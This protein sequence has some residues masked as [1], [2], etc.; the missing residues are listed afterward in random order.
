MNSR[1][2]RCKFCSAVLPPDRHGYAKYCDA[3]RSETG[4]LTK[5]FFSVS[6]TAEVLSIKE[7][8]AMK[9]IKQGQL[10]VRLLFN[11]F[12]IVIN[13]LEKFVKNRP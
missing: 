7:K 4:D 10:S 11:H 5:T 3:G 9:L 13:D 1:E 2:K 12:Y 6:E 8:Q